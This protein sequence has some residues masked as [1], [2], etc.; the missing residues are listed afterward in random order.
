[1]TTRPTRAKVDGDEQVEILR[2]IWNEMK[3]LN[4]RVDKTNERLDGTNERLEATKD[5]LV[6]EMSGLRTELKSEIDVLRKNVVEVELRL[7][8]AVTELS[9]DVRELSGLIHGWREEHREDRADVRSRVER[10]EKH[11]GL[12]R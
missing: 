9:T 12:D 3:G 2:A 10:I 11:L 8:T 6:R 7:A 1:M 5:E 4:A